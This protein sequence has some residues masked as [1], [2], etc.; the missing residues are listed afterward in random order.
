AVATNAPFLI[1]G[2]ASGVTPASLTLTTNCVG[3]AA[4]TYTASVTLLPTGG[5]TGPLIPVTVTVSPTPMLAASPTTLAFTSDASKP[6]FNFATL[7]VTGNVPIAFTAAAQV[8]VGLNWLS[9]T[10]PSGRSPI[11]VQVGVNPAGLAASN[12]PYAGKIVLAYGT[13]RLIVPVTLTITTPIVPVIASSSAASGLPS[14]APESI[15]SA[16]GSNLAT[17]TLTAADLPLPTSLGGITVRVKDSAGVERLAPIFFVSPGQVNY[18][19]PAGSAAGMATITIGQ[20]TG[21]VPINS[22]APGIFTANSNGKGAPAATAALYGANGT[23]TP[24]PV[25][26]CGSGVGSCTTVPIPLGA[27]MDQVFLTLYGTGIR[28][29]S[30]LV[31]VKCNVGGV[32]VPVTFADVQ[33]GFIGLDQIN[34]MLPRSLAGAGDADLVLTVD[35]QA[36]NTVRVSIP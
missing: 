12:A 20:A 14:V 13:A 22:I 27:A 21:S 3:L 4:N 31:H 1:I 10:P 5:T 2:P 33:G 28:G 23:V 32:D 29:R 26:Q 24:E 15:A 19:I 18:L 25:F 6:G 34:V 30:S 16:Y 17:A 9:V 36:A 35:G 11:A 8:D 7:N